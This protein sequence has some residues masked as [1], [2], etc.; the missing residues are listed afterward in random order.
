[1]W[2]APGRFTVSIAE[3]AGMPPEINIA[4]SIF[5]I[6]IGLSLGMRLL[7]RQKPAAGPEKGG[8]DKASPSRRR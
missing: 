5:G 7:G 8:S 6:I 4:A 1:M 3:D 2:K